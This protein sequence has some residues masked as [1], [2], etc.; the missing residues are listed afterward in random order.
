MKPKNAGNA[1]KAYS[2]RSTDQLTDLVGD[3]IVQ[4]ATNKAVYNNPSCVQVDRGS[5]A[6]AL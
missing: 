6:R 5:D 4:H 1:E 2:D 3:R